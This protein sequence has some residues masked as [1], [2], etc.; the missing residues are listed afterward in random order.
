MSYQAT[1]YN[2]LIVS[3]G[4][5][6]AERELARDMIN[7]W[8]ATHSRSRKIVLQPV[9][10]ET[11]S[12][13]EMGQRAQGVLNHQILQDADVVVGIFWSRIGTPTGDALSGS[14]E[15]IQRHMESG[16]PT[17]IYFSDA[18]GS[19]AMG[20]SEQ[21]Q[22]L[23]IWRQGWC[24]PRG[25]SET[26]RLPEEFK[27]KFR[28]QLATKVNDDPY[29][30][31]SAIGNVGYVI[32]ISDP[33]DPMPIDLSPEA[34]TLLVEAAA[35]KGG[36]ILYM[37]MMSGPE[38]QTN[39]KQFVESGN[40]RS[41]AIWESA[42]EELRNGGLVKAVGHKGQVFQITREGYDVADRVK[43]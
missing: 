14:V 18:P 7:E 26:F 3:P 33:T 4:D 2:V 32:D 37:K 36:T 22:R 30:V 12:H 42:L 27:D 29:F 11:H 17:M 28:R 43:A 15:E 40:P 10:W 39:N 35:D 5:V 38:L 16:K 6:E 41:A 13:P 1:V 21:Y 31:N 24:A 20:A 8:N 19:L 23:T 34:K 25:L 9:G